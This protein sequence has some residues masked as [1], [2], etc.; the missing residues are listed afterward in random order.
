MEGDGTAEVLNNIQNKIVEFEKY[1][2]QL[3]LDIK[4]LK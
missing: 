2:D 3:Q 1:Q 4:V